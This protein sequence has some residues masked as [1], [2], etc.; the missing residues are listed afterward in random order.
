MSLN[1][2]SIPGLLACRLS[3]LTI[4]NLVNAKHHDVMTYL[5]NLRMP[6]SL[7]EDIEPSEQIW[8]TLHGAPAQLSYSYLLKRDLKS[9]MTL[10]EIASIRNLELR[11]LVN[12]LIN[13][14]VLKRLSLDEVR[15]QSKVAEQENAR[16][17]QPKVE[18]PRTLIEFDMTAARRQGFDRERILKI[19]SLWISELLHKEG[20]NEISEMLT[21]RSINDIF[22]F[23]PLENLP[24]II[25]SGL[26]TLD[27][28][29]KSNAK[30]RAIDDVRFDEIGGICTSIGFP[31][32]KMLAKNNYDPNKPMAVISIS[33]ETLLAVPWVALPTNAASREMRGLVKGPPENLTGIKALRSLFTEQIN[34]SDGR[35]MARGDLGIP[36]HFTTDPQAEVIFLERVPP[37]FIKTIYLSSQAQSEV[38]S[39]L[40]NQSSLSIK[41]SL[42]NS[43]FR[44]RVD[45]TFWSGAR[46][47][48]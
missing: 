14:R 43:Y 7:L 13:Y 40:L 11:Q 10:G 44:P 20:S 8:A 35:Q 15:E 4:A 17:N 29:D 3:P 41:V 22:H 18:N 12:E 31:N 26:L 47:V 42:S 9:G 5:E 34:R 37:H 1:L 23:T 19:K 2:S 16:Q 25:R 48:G 33:A 38:I 21:G 32:Y 36:A 24:G 27:E 30:F 39:K 46:M 6:S 28:L 45:A